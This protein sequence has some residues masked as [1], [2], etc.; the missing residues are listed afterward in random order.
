MLSVSNCGLGPQASTVIAEALLAN[1]DIK[2]TKLMISRSR[3]ETEGALALAKY[4]Q[5]YDS[6]EHL[7][8]FQNGIRDDGST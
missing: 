1:E 8:I 2:L 3:V 5:S 7:E 4:F 6:L